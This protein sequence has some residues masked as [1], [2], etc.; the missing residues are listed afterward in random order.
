MEN[1]GRM[2]QGWEAD[3]VVLKIELD[4]NVVEI[5]D[6]HHQW[7]DVPLVHL[8]VWTHEASGKPGIHGDILQMLH[9]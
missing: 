1:V 5:T 4:R 3:R 2:A 8:K 9:D 6:F 7:N